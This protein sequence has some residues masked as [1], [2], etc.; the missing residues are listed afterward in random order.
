MPKRKLTIEKIKKRNGRVVPFNQRKITTAI[1]KA[2][3]AVG[4]KDEKR[5]QWLSDKVVSI[6]EERFNGHTIATVE[7]IQ[8]IVES[9]LMRHGHY[10]T[11]KAYILYRDLHNKIRDVKSLID[12]DELIG[13]YINGI[14]WRIKENSN[15]AFSLQGL[16][17]HVASAISRHYW[18]NQFYPKEV[19]NA[20][21]QGDLHLHD[22]QLLAPYCVGCLLYTSPSPR[23]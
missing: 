22:L 11:A 12:S 16:N 2:A 19:R 9:V 21:Q 7:Q 18:L 6:L 14:D 4:G 5:A 20:H 8:D 13:N 1:W 10:T 15:M 23:D 3:E 17:N